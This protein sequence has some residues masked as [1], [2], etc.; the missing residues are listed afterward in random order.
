MSGYD[1]FQASNNKPLPIFVPPTHP[2]PSHIPIFSEQEMYEEA[3]KVE[4]AEQERQEI[5][6]TRLSMAYQKLSI[7]TLNLRASNQKIQE[8]NMKLQAERA[9]N[10][11]KE[12]QA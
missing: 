4:Q 1:V 3:L 5:A 11:K 7:A 2:D 12:D 8:L 10:S 9:K 6:F